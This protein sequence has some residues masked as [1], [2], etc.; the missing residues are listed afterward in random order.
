[1]GKV[2]EL[3]KLV[4]HQRAITDL[5][6]ATAD[7]DALKERVYSLE[8]AIQSDERVKQQTSQLKEAAAKESQLTAKLASLEEEAAIY[9]TRVSQFERGVDGKDKDRER[10][11][12]RMKETAERLRK[13]EEKITTLEGVSVAR[14]SGG[15]GLGANFA[16]QD[17]TDLRGLVQGGK[18][19]VV[20]RLDS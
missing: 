14:R 20:S 3:N 5:R 17:R 11:K 16:P 1:M 7:R 12:E 6:E 19:K 8:K 2:R 13:T 10:E 9:R 15:K 4:Q 18:I